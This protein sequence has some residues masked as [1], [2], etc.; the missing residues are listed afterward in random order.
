[1]VKN[2]HAEKKEHIIVLLNSIPDANHTE[3]TRQ[4]GMAVCTVKKSER[5]WANKQRMILCPVSDLQLKEKSANNLIEICKD[6]PYD[7][8]P[9]TTKMLDDRA[10]KE[11]SKHYWTG[12]E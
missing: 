8:A 4:A 7:Q 2:L 1:M 12:I 5:R 6:A 9:D 3:I 11:V 10:F